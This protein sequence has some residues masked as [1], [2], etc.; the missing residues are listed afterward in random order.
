M[1]QK[2][3]LKEC[4][5]CDK[6]QGYDCECTV[7]KYLLLIHDQSSKAWTIIADS[8]DKEFVEKELENIRKSDPSP[9]LI[10]FTGDFMHV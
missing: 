5:K 6:V 1:A 10:I 7:D 2:P 8:T 9:M 4:E 3:P